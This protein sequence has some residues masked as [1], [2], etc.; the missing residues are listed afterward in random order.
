MVVVLRGD[1]VT[2]KTID[3]NGEQVDSTASEDICET[4]ESIE[5]DESVK[6]TILEVDSYGGHPVAAEEIANSLKRAKKPIV[7]LIRGAATSGGY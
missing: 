6:A 5:E 2:Y 7:G 4:I 3:A 1:I